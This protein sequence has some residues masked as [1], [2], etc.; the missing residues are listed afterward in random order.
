MPTLVRQ[1][2]LA[3]ASRLLGAYSALFGAENL[4]V[5]LVLHEEA[6]TTLVRELV[7]LADKLGLPTVAINA[8]LCATADEVPTADLVT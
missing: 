6:D 7:R 8:V 3:L 5:E 1:G 4:F 2:D